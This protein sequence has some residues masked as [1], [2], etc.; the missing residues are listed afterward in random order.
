VVLGLLLASG[1]AG[2]AVGVVVID[3]AGVVGAV[4]V[5]RRLD[6]PIGAAPVFFD[7]ALA[8]T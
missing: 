7:R 3:P 8:A 1:E 4:V 6:L 2:A 5:G